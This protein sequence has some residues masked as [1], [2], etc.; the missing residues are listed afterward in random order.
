MRIFYQYFLAL[1]P[2]QWLKNFLLFIPLIATHQINNEKIFLSMLM[3][4]SFSFVASSVYIFNDLI[5]LASDKTHPRKKFRP[6][7][8]QKIAKN[9]GK[10]FGLL[11]L[12]FGLTIGYYFVIKW[13]YMFF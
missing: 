4:I 9:H 12:F 11:V 10:I 13:L 1:R 6:F 7:A 5:D 2:H 3:F 8:S